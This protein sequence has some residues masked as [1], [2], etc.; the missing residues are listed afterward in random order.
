MS[1]KERNDQDNNRLAVVLDV[2]TLALFFKKQDDTV[3][4]HPHLYLLNLLA[5]LKQL[6]IDN[7]VKLHF[8]FIAHKSSLYERETDDEQYVWDIRTVPPT[9]TQISQRIL[10]E[11]AVITHGIDGG[12]HTTYTAAAL[13]EWFEKTYLSVLFP[14]ETK[15]DSE[16]I[17]EKTNPFNRSLAPMIPTQTKGKEKDAFA[18]SLRFFCRNQNPIVISS[19]H[20]LSNLVPTSVN[21]IKL[22]P[23]SYQGGFESKLPSRLPK[24]E[25]KTLPTVLI[26][27]AQAIVYTEQECGPHFFALRPEILLAIQE[28]IAS[29]SQPIRIFVCSDTKTQKSFPNTNIISELTNII[30]NFSSPDKRPS[31]NHTPETDCGIEDTTS[32]VKTKWPEM[33][34][35]HQSQKMF[36]AVVAMDNDIRTGLLEK[37]RENIISRKTIIS[38]FTPNTD[39]E[40]I[41]QTELD[42]LEKAI[43][44]IAAASEP[45]DVKTDSIDS[46][47]S[48][49]VISKKTAPGVR[50]SD[51]H[52]ITHD[53][54]YD[55][56]G[57]FTTKPPKQQY[58]QPCDRRRSFESPI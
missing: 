42:L 48:G 41:S 19:S 35:A 22:P 32:W 2:T 20:L 50:W 45:T 28:L 46:D 9:L 27:E 39:L 33:T 7:D 8:Y 11:P 5:V 34:D 43:D 16:A 55:P 49:V 24:E 25:L 54:P 1:R 23:Q 6:A 31:I 58:D 3:S 10:I 18:K 14:D 17:T 52:P 29:R 47:D 56:C 12:S 36:F 38:N 53:F 37:I 4:C 26:I 44:E 15:T 57:L 13:I 51:E 40:I 30:N 21:K